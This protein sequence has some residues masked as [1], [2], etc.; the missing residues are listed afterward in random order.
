MKDV[1]ISVGNSIIWVL[2]VD[3]DSSSLAVDAISDSDNEDDGS[4][5]VFSSMDESKD[6]DVCRFL[7]DSRGDGAKL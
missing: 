5:N 6:E 1:D 2:P 7:R 4:Y 3:A